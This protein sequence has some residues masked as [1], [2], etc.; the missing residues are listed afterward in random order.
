MK[1]RWNMDYKQLNQLIELF[2][3]DLD[4]ECQMLEVV[5][6]RLTEVQAMSNMSVADFRSFAQFNLLLSKE[7]VRRKQAVNKCYEY[8]KAVRKLLYSGIIRNGSMN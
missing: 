4:F 1:G 5:Q 8:E 7:M 2:K 3:E 6:E